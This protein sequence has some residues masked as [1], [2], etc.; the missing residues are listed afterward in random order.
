[1]ADNASLRSCPLL[2]GST[3]GGPAAGQCYLAARGAW[4]R[5]VSLAVEAA[6]P[7]AH[8]RKL[9][10]AGYVEVS[11]AFH[12][13]K[14]ISWYRLSAAGRTA[15]TAHLAGLEDVIRVAKVS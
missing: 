12:E 4:R 6:C 14:P 3:L 11:K 5:R 2:A 8:L 13:R 15:L 9:E 1:M 10:E 7:G